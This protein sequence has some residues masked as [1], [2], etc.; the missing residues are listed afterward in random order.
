MG[1]FIDEDRAVDPK[2]SSRQSFVEQLSISLPGDDYI[3]QQ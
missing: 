3:R 1:F 2:L